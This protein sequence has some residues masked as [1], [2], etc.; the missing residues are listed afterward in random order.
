LA[1]AVRPNEVAPQKDHVM[2]LVRSAL[3]ATAACLIG[4]AAYAQPATGDTSPPAGDQSQQTPPTG[5]PPGPT[6]S[7]DMNA[8]APSSPDMSG[9][10]NMNA[11][12]T[13]AASNTSATVTTDANGTQVIA[14]QPVPDTPANRKAYGKP[15]SM[16]GKRTPPIGN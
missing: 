13:G 15:L 5:N 16:T 7:S 4:A 14:S 10:S 8:G 9:S 11:A 6:G 2:P 12:P 3:I 1:F